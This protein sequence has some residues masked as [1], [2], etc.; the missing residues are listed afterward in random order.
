MGSL[1]HFSLER[2]A[3]VANRGAFVGLFHVRHKDLLL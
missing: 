3:I 2:R 1:G